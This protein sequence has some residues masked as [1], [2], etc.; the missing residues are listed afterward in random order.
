[1]EAHSVGGGDPRRAVTPLRMIFWGG[2]ICLI[3]IN[4]TLNRSF[5]V[6]LLDDFVGMLLITVGV[7]RLT[8][9][10]EEPKYRASMNLVKI[11]SVIS[12]LK[13][14]IKHW[15]FDAGPIWD[16]GWEIYVFLELAGVLLFCRSMRTL[17]TLWGLERSAA[18]WETTHTLY[19]ALY[20]FPLGCVHVYIMVAL[21]TGSHGRVDVGPWAL[22]FLVL[23]F[24]PLIHLF[25]STSR[26]KNAAQR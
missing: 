8:A 14:L 4:V 12:T 26:M 1:M 19:L 16:W 24:I 7:F 6:D 21:A 5:K 2:L 15:N 10:D 25:V 3:D 23:L 17:C 11:I 13:A 20:V 9:L 18:S 22:L